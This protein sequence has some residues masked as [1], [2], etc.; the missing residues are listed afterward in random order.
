MGSRGEFLKVGPLELGHV[1]KT[2]QISL[3]SAHSCS[4]YLSLS[5]LLF[6]LISQQVHTNGKA[7]LAALQLATAKLIGAGKS[8]SPIVA[9]VDSPALRKKLKV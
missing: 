5:F 2:F 4:R 8:Q 1:A 7:E 9:A 6:C 3:S